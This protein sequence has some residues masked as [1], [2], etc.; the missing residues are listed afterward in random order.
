[1]KTSTP[2]I[3]FSAYS[4]T[5]KTTLLKSLIPLLREKKLCLAVIKHA[6][7]DFEIDHPGKDS[8]ELRKADAFQ[9]LIS[10]GKRKALITEFDETQTEP[11]LAELIAELDHDR[12][13]LILVEGF[14]HEHFDKI[15]LHREVLAKPY[16]HELDPDIIALAT[17]HPVTTRLP[18]LDINQP[19]A[20]ADFI[21][22]NVYQSSSS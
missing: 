1:V 9:V 8:F 10:S 20:I 13:D 18:L 21:Y 19:Q 4:G 16:L 17:D 6:H 12:I 14:K 11:S 3:G 7:H 5:G 2:V 22:K 15:E